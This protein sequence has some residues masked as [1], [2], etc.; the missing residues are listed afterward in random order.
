MAGEPGRLTRETVAKRMARHMRPNRGDCKAARAGAE[1]SAPGGK[2]LRRA[3][4]S[5]GAPS[6]ARRAG[7][8]DAQIE[9]KLA[10]IIGRVGDE[11]GARD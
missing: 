6:R 3:P 9:N 11:Q 8:I 1:W 4:R 10:A 2:G 5:P 7:D